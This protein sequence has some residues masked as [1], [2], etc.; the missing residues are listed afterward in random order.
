MICLP[1]D[2]NNVQGHPQCHWQKAFRLFRITF[3]MQL[4]QLI[5]LCLPADALFPWRPKQWMYK[6]DSFPVSL[7]N[8]LFKPTFWVKL[9]HQLDELCLLG[10]S[11]SSLINSLFK[12]ISWVK[13]SYWPDQLCLW[14]YLR[15][16]VS[17]SIFWPVYSLGQDDWNEVQHDFFGQVILLALAPCDA[18]SIV[19]ATTAL[20]RS[21][22][23]KWGTTWHLIM[24]HHWCKHWHP[25]M[26]MTSSMA[27]LYSWGHDD[28]NERQHDVLLMWWY[29][30][31]H[32]MSS[33]APLNSLGQDDHNKCNITFL[34]LWCHWHQY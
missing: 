4:Y 1:E 23:L 29:W 30:H 31:W 6:P 20:N 18:K 25:E 5:Q 33:M 21:T 12:T 24:W 26:L 32:Y 17:L 34:A 15:M 11:L 28:S 13:L 22:Q 14:E 3:Q 2:L 10:Y 8:S 27:P 9:V 7:M 19:N 16:T